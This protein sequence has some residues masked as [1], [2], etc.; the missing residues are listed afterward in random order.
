MDERQSDAQN[1]IGP[2]R[3]FADIVVQFYPDDGVHSDQDA[4]CPSARGS[5]PI[6]GWHRPKSIVA[7]KLMRVIATWP[8]VARARRA[9]IRTFRNHNQTGNTRSA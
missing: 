9:R 6:G 4:P 1:F 7:E 5:P 3:E 8:F 2:Q